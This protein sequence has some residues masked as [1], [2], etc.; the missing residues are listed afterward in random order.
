MNRVLSWLLA[1][2]VAL[3][4]AG[5]AS[6]STGHT[7][8]GSG[9]WQ[10]AQN[11]G[12]AG[13]AEG[14]PAGDECQRAEKLLEQAR[15]EMADAGLLDPAGRRRSRRMEAARAVCREA[16]TILAASA[17]RLDAALAKLPRFIDPKDKP[18]V[19]ERDQ[20]RRSLL[21]TQLALAGAAMEIA[22]TY[23]PGEPE[24]KANLAGAAKQYGAIFDKH[25]NDLA[26]LYARL[27]QARCGRNWARPIRR[28]RFSS[29][30]CP[31]PTDPRPWPC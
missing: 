8:G 1:G 30:F 28:W 4:G 29:S 13:G 15:R 24:N 7:S 5:F 10:V 27:G 2:S 22:R 9:V 6:V 20:L 31:S 21:Q 17:E 11:T 14:S 16:E 19:Q 26:G 3:G 12:K 25:H 23:P 18:K